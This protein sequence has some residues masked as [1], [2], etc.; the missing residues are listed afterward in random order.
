MGFNSAFKGLIVW[1]TV[2]CAGATCTPNGHQYTVTYTRCHIDTINS[3]DDGHMA[4]P[5][6]QRIEINIHEKRIVRQV[7][8]LQRLR[9]LSRVLYFATRNKLYLRQ[10]H[11][12]L[13]YNLSSVQTF[14][15]LNRFVVMFVCNKSLAHSF[16][17]HADPNI[18]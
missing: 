10:T 17:Y 3:P 16:R 7:G 11:V 13:N 14:Q 12:L 5:N 9:R 6:V 18:R 2:W 1:M 8:Y 15:N 4:T